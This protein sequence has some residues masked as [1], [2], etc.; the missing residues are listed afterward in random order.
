M[1]IAK[2]C[3]KNVMIRGMPVK[4]LYVLYVEGVK[5]A[6]ESP[7]YFIKELWEEK[8]QEILEEYRN[9][10]LNGRL[11]PDV[12]RKNNFRLV[13]REPRK[14]PWHGKCAYSS[15]KDV[16][17]DHGCQLYTY[18]GSNDK[19]NDEFTFFLIS[20]N[21]CKRLEECAIN[22]GKKLGMNSEVTL[23]HGIQKLCIK[24]KVMRII[25]EDISKL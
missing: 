13:L 12:E 23:L 4:K 10:P 3:M 22:L 1:D 15:L 17:F 8:K 16:P 19:V 25:K 20:K 21:N 24:K 11:Y 18:G 6:V 9:A 14:K 2:V 5:A 7:Y